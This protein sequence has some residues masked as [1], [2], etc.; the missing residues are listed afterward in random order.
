MVVLWN[1]VIHIN[2]VFEVVAKHY[3][4]SSEYNSDDEAAVMN[5]IISWEM[6][7]LEYIIVNESIL[8]FTNGYLKDY[9]FKIKA[10]TIE[11]FRILAEINIL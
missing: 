1:L 7:E 9:N 11:E 4:P 10:M 5:I 8:E 2:S 3:I 6:L